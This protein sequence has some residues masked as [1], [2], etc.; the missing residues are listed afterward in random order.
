MEWDEV[1][2]KCNWFEKIIEIKRKTKLWQA[3]LALLKDIHNF[4][5]LSYNN[6]QVSI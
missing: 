2:I 1:Q 4:F 5:I 3:L 6:V